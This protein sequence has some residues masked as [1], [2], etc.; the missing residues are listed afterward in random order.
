MATTRLDHKENGSWAAERACANVAEI[1][2]NLCS[3]GLVA[4]AATPI[5]APL[6]GGRAERVVV[7]RRGGLIVHELSRERAAQDE[8]RSAECSPREHPLGR[9]PRRCG[10]RAD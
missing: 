6:T 3:L 7:V 9:H 8:N 1:C 2:E 10:N 5:I 4:V